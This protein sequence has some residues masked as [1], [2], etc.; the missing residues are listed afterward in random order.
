M[1]AKDFPED[2]ELLSFFEV[3]PSLLDTDAPWLYNAITF[4][5]EYIDELLYCTFSP[6]YGDLDLT[7]I[8]NQKPKITLSLHNIEAI[9]ILKDPSGEHLKVIFNSDSPL[10][11]FLL[12]L[13]PE[14]SIVWG[15]DY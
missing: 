5:K 10:L 11:N 12:T 3:E 9:K 14:V 2:Y 6:S 1:L 4:K 7:L 8:R 13:K 15:T